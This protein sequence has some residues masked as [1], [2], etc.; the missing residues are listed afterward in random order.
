MNHLKTLGLGAF[1]VIALLLLGAATASATVL[2]KTTTNPC[3]GH[4]MA[5]TAFEAEGNGVKIKTPFNENYCE[6]S[7]I[8]GKTSATGSATETVT[9]SIESLSFN[10]CSCSNGANPEVGVLKLPSLEVHHLSETDNGLVT[11]GGL[12]LTVRCTDNKV[13]CTFEN[14]SFGEGALRLT[15]GEEEPRL[16]VKIY[17]KWTAG[18]SSEFLCGGSFGIPLILWEGNYQFKSPTPLYVM[19]G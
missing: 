13:A 2:C 12:K 11:G 7:T 10:K 8:T 9:A 16:H 18:D 17:L 5:G 4:Y 15:G 3:E 1:A 19:P 6:Y 14:S